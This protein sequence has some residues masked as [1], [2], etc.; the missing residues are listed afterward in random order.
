MSDIPATRRRHCD[1]YSNDPTRESYIQETIEKVRSGGYPSFRHASR[2]TQVRQSFNEIASAE[3]D[4]C[5]RSLCRRLRTV[6]RVVIIAQH[7]LTP[8]NSCSRPNRRP[9]CW[10]GW[11]TEPRWVFLSRGRTLRL[12]RQRFPGKSS[13]K[14][15]TG[16]SYNATARSSSLRRQRGL[17]QS[18]QQ[19]SNH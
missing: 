10:S 14:P 6:Q 2:M 3:H 16:N 18:T 1:R 11:S 8:R 4:A 13:E 15:G 12:R 19:C 17:A 9:L 5:R 7:Q